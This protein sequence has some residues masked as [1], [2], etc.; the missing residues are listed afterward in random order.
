MGRPMMY[1]DAKMRDDQ[2]QDQMRDQMTDGAQDTMGRCM[3][4]D[5]E[6]CNN[7]F[8]PD[9]G[10]CEPCGGKEGPW[11]CWDNGLPQLGAQACEAVCFGVSPEQAAMDAAKYNADAMAKA[12][13]NANMT[14]ADQ[15]A[16]MV[17]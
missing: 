12:Q 9:M 17:K 4:N 7:D 2:M 16:D 15:E 3:C 13:A 6:F 1:E 11:N 10:F 5:G 8:G 14:I